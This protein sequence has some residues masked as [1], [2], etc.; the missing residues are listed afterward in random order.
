M[1]LYTLAAEEEDEDGHI[2]EWNGVLIVRPEVNE[3]F[4]N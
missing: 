4:L 1:A 3:Y 2:T